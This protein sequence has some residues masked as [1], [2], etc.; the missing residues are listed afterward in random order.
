MII[1]AKHGS[2][3]TSGPLA[4]YT[5]PAT[6]VS[7]LLTTHITMVVLAAIVVALRLISR[8]LVVK[9]PGWDD[10]MIMIAMVCY[11][12]WIRPGGE[13]LTN[14]AFQ[15]FGL[16]QTVLTLSCIPNGAAMHSWDIPRSAHL[17]Y[18]LKVRW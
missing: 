4:S 2:N 1:P 8:Y 6:G 3:D 18:T 5:K 14:K 15:I 7:R 13:L 10:Y 12:E 9:N 16:V 17:S 11:G